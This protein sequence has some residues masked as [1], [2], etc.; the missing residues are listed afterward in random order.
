[1]FVVRVLDGLS[2]ESSAGPVPRGAQQR[3]RLSL[4]AVLALAG[5]RG[6]SRERI[7]S[8]LW[9]ES[10]ATR[11]RHALD[12]LLYTTRRDLGSD[13]IVSGGTDLRLNTSLVQTDV[14]A[15]DTA[16]AAARWEEAVAA[17][18]GAVLRG[19]HLCES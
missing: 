11:A 7:Q 3:R 13:A 8:Y 14:G 15:F 5:D 17:Y 10:D 4:L 9:P 2:I 1:M 19:V 6:L 18:A 16:I 12:Q